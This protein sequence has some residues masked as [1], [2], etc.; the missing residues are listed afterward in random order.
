MSGPQ[1]CRS[2]PS[3]AVLGARSFV[4][5]GFE[6]CRGGEGAAPVSDACF[7]LFIGIAWWWDPDIVL[8]GRC[9]SCS[10]RQGRV[11]RA[12]ILAVPL[13]S[14]VHEVSANCVVSRFMPS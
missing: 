2:S 14:R 13:A 8:E 11:F 1:K 12:N 4:W 10:R 6:T 7:G 3:C 5:V 9:D